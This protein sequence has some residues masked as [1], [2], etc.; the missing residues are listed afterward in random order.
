ML[1]S[2][3]L[4]ADG[5]AVLR[6]IPISVMSEKLR[7]GRA[8]DPTLMVRCVIVPRFVYAQGTSFAH[9]AI[10]DTVIAARVAECARATAHFAQVLKTGD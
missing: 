9:G 8:Y 4:P 10:T 2:D 6:C 7:S 3:R 5:L 1:P